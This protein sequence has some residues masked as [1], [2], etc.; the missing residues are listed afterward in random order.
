MDVAVVGLGKI[1]L[2][3]AA[4]IAGR[5]HQVHGL[6][7]DPDVVASVMDGRAPF[8]GEPELDERLTA[9]RGAHTLSATTDPGAA[10]AE[11]DVVIVVV[12][13]IVDVSGTPDFG[14]LD[15]ATAAVG[16]HLK[17][18][19]LVSYETT[20]PLGT[21]RE[22]FVPA[23]EEASGLTAG[24]DLFVCHSPERVSSGR[25]FRDLRG[26]PKLVGGVD[27]ASSARAVEFYTS[28][29]EFDERTDL[30]RPNGVWDLGSSE[31]AE[32]A[33][34]A[35]T[36]YRDVNIAYANELAIIAEDRGLDVWQVI[37]ACNSQPFSHIHQPGIAVGGHCIPVYPHFLLAGAPR[38]RLPAVA[39]E[40]NLGMPAH[41]VEALAEA[42]GGLAGATV[43]VVGIAYRSGVKEHAFSGVFAIRDA[44]ERE[45]AAVVTHDPLY[46]VDEV[47]AL[48]LVPWVPGA[49][50]DA[51]VLHTPGEDPDPALEGPWPGL[52]AV[53]DG[54]NAPAAWTPQGVRMIRLGRGGSE[55]RSPA[56]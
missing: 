5:G 54:R 55:G 42:L 12:P 1:G 27:G 11:A 32:L 10:V 43:L 9:A 19:V 44:L 31:A 21:T 18:G 4:Q 38:A 28:A 48:G 15:G 45:G 50:C 51:V 41:C 17:P 47:L 29:L 16:P 22:R 3:L 56:R 13:L 6:D 36:T 34:L 20:L 23:L 33:K 24:R 8:P 25:V 49:P 39:R 37:E 26:Y 46:Q 14:A 7:I 35:E 53:V 30:P 2:P 40:V 52:R